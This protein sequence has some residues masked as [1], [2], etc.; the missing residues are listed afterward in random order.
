MTQMHINETKQMIVQLERQLQPTFVAENVSIASCLIVDLDILEVGRVLEFD[1]T[2][3]E[4]LPH[5]HCWY[6][7]ELK[8]S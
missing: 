6:G 8:P 2:Y 1:E 5:L 7:H 3:E 4:H